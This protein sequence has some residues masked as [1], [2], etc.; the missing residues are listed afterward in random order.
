MYQQQKRGN[1]KLLS[2]IFLPTNFTKYKLFPFNRKGNFFSQL[3]ILKLNC[4]KALR[5]MIFGSEIRKKLS[6][7]RYQGSKNSANGTGTS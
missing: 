7:I 5:N 6:Q 4:Y 3:K 1:K 2:Y